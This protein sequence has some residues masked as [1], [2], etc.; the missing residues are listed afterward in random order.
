MGGGGGGGFNPVQAVKN[1]GIGTA[2]AGPTGAISGALSS[3]I[4]GLKNTPFDPGTWASTL[5]NPFGG[6]GGGGSANYGSNMPTPTLGE[7]KGLA[8]LGAAGTLGANKIDASPWMNLAMNQQKLEEGQALGNAVSGQQ[9]ALAQGRANLAMKG[10]LSGGSAERM[11]MQGANDLASARQNV[12]AQGAIN[13]GNIALGNV[14]RQMDVDKFNASMQQDADRFNTSAKL[15][16]LAAQ[17]QRDLF[18]YGEEMKLKGG[19]MSGQAIENSG[20][21]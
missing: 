2:I 15:Q 14:D 13:R 20:K 16:D 3:V 5:S 9:Q 18:K 4:P 17:N 1:T 19:A 10:G 12:F 7:Y 11:A 6:G 21:K 8:S